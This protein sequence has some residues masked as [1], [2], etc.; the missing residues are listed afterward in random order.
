M[1]YVAALNS[2]ILFKKCT[3]NQNQKVKGYAFKAFMLD[4]SE[5]DSARRKKR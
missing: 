4:S 3:T 1:L 5:N 2:F